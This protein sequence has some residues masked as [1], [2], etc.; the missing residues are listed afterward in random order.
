MGAG[1]MPSAQRP[2]GVAGRPRAAG[3]RLSGG[4]SVANTP[5]APHAAAVSLGAS[6]PR[7]CVGL[8]REQPECK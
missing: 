6:F 8:T 3:A 7:V 2:A 5:C 4:L 1:D